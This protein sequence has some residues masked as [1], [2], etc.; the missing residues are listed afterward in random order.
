MIL[1]PTVDDLKWFLF[2][3][4][5]YSVMMFGGLYLLEFFRHSSLKED[6]LV[7]ACVLPGAGVMFWVFILEP[8]LDSRLGDV[9]LFSFFTGWSLGWSVFG[10]PMF[11]HKRRLES[12]QGLEPS[13]QELK[14]RSYDTFV[15]SI[16]AVPIAILMI[17][18]SD[19]VMLWM[20]SEIAITEMTGDPFFLSIMLA[21]ATLSLLSI[22][23]PIY[24]WKK[25]MIRF[26]M[27]SATLSG[28][29]FAGPIAIVA[30]IFLWRAYRIGGWSW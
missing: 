26:F 23:L 12:E 21:L 15:G 8:R 4:I 18:L 3:L 11:K 24:A 10:I 28:F 13:N 29:S 16:L 22:L 2:G 19:G 27:L 7:L 9:L 25:R 20:I 30:E 17:G 5:I 1:Y 14:V 6:L